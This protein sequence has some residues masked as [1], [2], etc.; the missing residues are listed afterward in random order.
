M[1]E[2]D[3]SRFRGF[4]FFGRRDQPS[5]SP[6]DSGEILSPRPSDSQSISRGAE[7]ELPEVQSHENGNGIEGVATD[8][9]LLQYFYNLKGVDTQAIATDRFI[10][11]SRNEYN[12]AWLTR[13]LVQN[14]VDHNPQDPG[15]LNGVR[16]T[17][18]P[19]T[20]GGRRYRIEGDWPFED[21]T[22]VLSPHS[23]KPEHRNTA[24]GNGIGLK[25]TA[26]RF[27][28]DFGVQK[29]EI[30]GEGWKAN[31]RLAKADEINW[32]W[33]NM[34][35]QTPLH[36]VK[37]DWLLADIEEVP[38]TGHNAYII[39]TDDPEVMKALDQLPTLGVSR[40]NPYL[41]KMDYVSHHGAF[42]WLPKTDELLPNRGRLFING[43]VMNFKDKG[44]TAEDYWVG[45]E[46][47]TIQLNNLRYRM[48]VDRPPVT[49]SDLG[50]YMDDMVD[51]MTKD[52]LIEQLHNSEHIWAGGVDSEYGF[53]RPGA[54]VVIAKLVNKLPYKKYDPQELQTYF[55]EKKFLAF[56]K[57]VSPNQ[58]EELREQGYIICP[59]YFEKIGMLPA[60]SKLSDE[61]AA[62]N[63]SPQFSRYRIEEVATEYGMEVSRE[64]F[65][66][67]NDTSEFISLMKDRL[68]G[69]VI[70]I[71]NNG[72]TP[73]VFRFTLQGD[74]SKDL[75][76]HPL[77]KPR[78]DEQKLLYFLRGV[79]G[80][81]LDKGVFKK[82]YSSQGEYVTTYKMHY[83]F[84][85][86]EDNL[87][88]RNI[89]FKSDQGVFLEVE[90]QDKY[91][92][93]F[94]DIFFAKPT[95]GEQ[96]GSIDVTNTVQ[97]NGE[98]LE[99]T[100]QEANHNSSGDTSPGS[101]AI[102]KDEV[103][104][105]NEWTPEQ[106]KLYQAAVA[107]PVSELTEDEK[108]LIQ[109]RQQ[110]ANRF[111]QIPISQPSVPESK[112]RENARQERVESSPEMQQRQKQLERHLPEIVEAVN[113]LDT[114]VPGSSETTEVQLSPTE[115]YLQWRDSERFYGKLGESAHYMSG[116]HLIEIIEDQNKAEIPSSASHSHVK[117]PEDQIV[118]ALQRKL[119]DVVKRINPAEDEVDD[120]EIV[121]EPSQ[122]QLAQLGL[123][124][125]FAHLT[126][127]VAIPND[128]FIYEGSG[129]KGIN[130]GQKAIGL[131][132]SL[133]N[134][135]F[136][137]A[138]RTFIHEIAHNYP[139]AGDH[140]NNFRHA[141]ESLFATT[142]D[143]ISETARNLEAGRAATP[144]EKVLLDM[145]AEWD[146]LRD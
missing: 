66:A 133:F 117:T 144:E 8:Q 100:D 105:S 21:P 12:A 94:R 129:S 65:T 92:Q 125:L 25:Q 40:E 118:G 110:L 57:K 146:K 37:H 44:K 4:R 142:I 68:Q 78:T 84:V 27:M 51:K 81:G 99:H 127:G 70:T 75:I 95:E 22:G 108:A 60:G 112:P 103:N 11:K 59:A 139:D 10:D 141:M 83:D 128:M 47:I 52:E 2:N 36:K 124:R 87:V 136:S 79:A 104:V 33:E 106:E 140:G 14:F 15:T 17:S 77:P 13:E 82:I 97:T 58:L 53:E 102:S 31:Y 3:S 91:I 43:Q 55:N 98:P 96:S 26:I 80:Y 74:I 86:E 39:E 41:Q 109:K 107:K 101:E 62:S 72:K 69:H 137:E 71:E 30:Q 50:L 135:K 45:P 121:L 119:Q 19:L 20:M 29:F 76:F 9:K 115:K 1:G 111:S 49:A 120:F 88:V 116:K 16:F 89:P 42:K 5:S 132:N 123:L 126:T 114:L 67:V 63:E 28:R 35:G 56:D 61:A 145:Q 38:K 23:D 130:L 64:E 90:L 54:Y 7:P 48:S 143:N 131:H 34:P 134:V 6:A 46:W 32:E 113:K 18:E 85:T 138:M 122:E 73:S 93:Q 24:G